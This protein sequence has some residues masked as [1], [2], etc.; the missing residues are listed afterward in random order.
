V[1]S[2]INFLE[3]LIENSN[4][5]IRKNSPTELTKAGALMVGVM[6]AVTIMNC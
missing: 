6:F 5:R 3:L 2:Y 4:S 1:A